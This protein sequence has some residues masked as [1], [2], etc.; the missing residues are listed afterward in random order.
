MLKALIKTGGNVLLGVV[1]MVGVEAV[2]LMGLIL[3]GAMALNMNVKEPLN[4]PKI[5]ISSFV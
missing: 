2:F 4:Q 3:M 5:P 1:V